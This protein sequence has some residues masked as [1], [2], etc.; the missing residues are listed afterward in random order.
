MLIP[1]ILILVHAYRTIQEG[2]LDNSGNSTATTNCP[3]LQQ[4]LQIQIQGE[5]SVST[6]V[7]PRR[8]EREMPI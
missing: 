2:K 7:T 5:S 6:P 3:C 1:P 4:S 8:Q